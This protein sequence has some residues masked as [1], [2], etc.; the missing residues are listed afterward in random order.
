MKVLELEYDH[1]GL[2]QAEVE[3]V[4]DLLKNGVR[5]HIQNMK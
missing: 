3:F 1:F 4:E 5:I 2:T